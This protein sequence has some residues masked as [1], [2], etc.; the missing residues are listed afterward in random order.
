MPPFGRSGRHATFDQIGQ[1]KQGIA[2]CERYV[3]LA[4]LD[5]KLLLEELDN[6]NN[7]GRID[8]AGGHQGGVVLQAIYFSVPE[9]VGDE[10][11]DLS[12]DGLELGSGVKRHWQ[13]TNRDEHHAVPSH[14]RQHPPNNTRN[15]NRLRL[16]P[17]Q[18]TSGILCA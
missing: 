13:R 16:F 1:S 5:S 9:P 18:L 3:A 4:D 6:L 2:V 17:Q 11:A 15:G 10:G 7:T 14:R 8:D 12:K